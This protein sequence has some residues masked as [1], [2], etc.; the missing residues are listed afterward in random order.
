MDFGWLFYISKVHLHYTREEFWEATHAEIY[1]MWKAHIKFNGW[2][3]NDNDENNTVSDANY[4]KVNIEDI[5]F[6]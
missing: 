4:K 3:I 5:S 2:K 1:K 6:L